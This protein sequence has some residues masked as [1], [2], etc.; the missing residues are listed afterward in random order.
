MWPGSL[1]PGNAFWDGKN[2]FITFFDRVLPTGDDN[3]RGHSLRVLKCW[4][5]LSD[6]PETHLLFT[7]RA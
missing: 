1:R 6:A 2:R 5:V 3:Y 4:P 7:D